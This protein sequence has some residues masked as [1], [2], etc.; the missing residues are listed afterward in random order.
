MPVNPTTNPEESAEHYAGD[1]EHFAQKEEFDEIIDPYREEFIKLVIQ[2]EKDIDKELVHLSSEIEGLSKKNQPSDLQIKVAPIIQGFFL[3]WFANLIVNNSTKTAEI[4]G[5]WHINEV[6]E[7]FNGLYTESITQKTQQTTNYLTN[8]LLQRKDP[9]NGITIGEKITWLSSGSLNAVRNIIRVGI[10]EGWS[11]VQMAK[12]IENYVIKPDVSLWTSPFEYF[13]KA[14]GYERRQPSLIPAG[15]IE[16]N[17]KRIARTEINNTW[18][19]ATLLSY[20]DMPWIAGYDWNLSPSH[21]VVDICDEWAEGSPYTYEE[22]S[23]F[24]HPHCMCNITVRFKDE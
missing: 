1:E 14:F 10:D 18:R 21:P 23:K 6:N 7:H 22:I 5:A 16:Y 9:F 15:S 3:G 19:Q 13:R 4:N 8:T 11:N 17:A 2:Q 24:G 12:N 20:K